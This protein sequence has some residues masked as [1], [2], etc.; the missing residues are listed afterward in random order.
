MSRAPTPSTES[1]A[2]GYVSR[3]LS[4]LPAEATMSEP[5]WLDRVEPIGDLD[6]GFESDRFELTTGRGWC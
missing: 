4:W 6:D 2:A 3:E 1:N 5:V